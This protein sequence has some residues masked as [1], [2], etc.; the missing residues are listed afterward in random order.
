MA[1]ERIKVKLDTGAVEW[2]FRQ[3]AATAFE[4]ME[5]PASVHGIPFYAANGTE[6]KNYGQRRP[7]G[8]SGDWKPITTCVNVAEVKSNLASGMKMIEADNRIILD[9]KPTIENDRKLLLEHFGPPGPH[10][11]PLGGKFEI[12]I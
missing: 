1:W 9:G 8:Y 5:T 4:I 3:D 2:V 7:C 11:G 12:T 6:I 10:W